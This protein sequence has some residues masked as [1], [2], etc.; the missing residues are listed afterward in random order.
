MKTWRTNDHEIRGR[1]LAAVLIGL[2]WV[3]LPW[4]QAQAAK[5]SYPEIYLESRD[6][7]VQLWE[8]GNTATFFL[9]SGFDLDRM[10]IECGA[11]VGTVTIDGVSYESGDA[12]RMDAL[13]ELHTLRYNRVNYDL[14]IM[15]SDGLPAVFVTTASG[16]L[17][18]LHQS[19]QNK[20][21][22]TFRLYDST[23]K[24][25]VSEELEHVKGR[26]DSTYS[27]PKKPYQIK[28]RR[29]VSLFGMPA[30]KRW[31]LLANHKEKSLIRNSIVFEAARF[32][33]E[34]YPIGDQFVDLYMNSQYVGTYE[35]CEKVEID[36]SRINVRDLQKATEAVNDLPL[37][38]YPRYGSYKAAKN[39]FKGYQIPNDPFDIT[40]GYLITLEKA[41]HYPEDFSGLVTRRSICFIVK[42]PENLSKAQ[43]EY[44]SA[45]VQQLE[46]AIYA[47]DGCDP[48]TG[49]HFTEL[50][51]LDSMAREYLLEE[52]F[53]NYDVNRSSQYIVKPSSAE[54]GLIYF[55]PAWDFDL[56]MG[57]WCDDETN[58]HI[59]SPRRMLASAGKGWLPSLYKHREFYERVITMY[60]EEMVPYLL[61][62]T[63]QTA[64]TAVMTLRQRYEALQASAA[65][66]FVR[67]PV[68]ENTKP[69]NTGT[70]YEANI[71]YLNDW[72]IQ[73]MDFLD[74]VWYEDYMTLRM[75]R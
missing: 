50:A 41:G 73:R 64:D 2:L 6:C 38:S 17:E 62:L 51:N 39:T 20:E 21:A 58:N 27:Q 68:L 52:V 31:V 67:W 13:E 12:V 63:G 1:W 47:K 28:F 49:K 70:T 59:A 24:L 72:L 66:N 11:S 25:T 5:T 45:W 10:T 69:V 32:L 35:L 55:G 61:A 23:G 74:T 29:R 8:F 16:G 46:D 48:E 30:A 4:K 36:S 37:D 7:R 54:G 43:G 42:S 18:L 22:G 40:G 57:G 33:G 75:M 14:K 9:P 53:K 19:K 71:A 34:R 44:L 60:Y 26:G 65:M 3:V 15:K 56:S